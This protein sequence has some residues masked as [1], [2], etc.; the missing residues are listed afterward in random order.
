MQNFVFHIPTK[1]IFGRDT[2]S[3]IGPETAA[4]GSRCL[5]VHGRAS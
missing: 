5:L 4:W 3:S 2:V 1:V